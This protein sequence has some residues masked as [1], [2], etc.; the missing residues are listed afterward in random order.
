M[1]GAAPLAGAAAL[2]VALIAGPR[3]RLHHHPV[4]RCAPPDSSAS[5][6]VAAGVGHED[7]VERRA[8]HA[9]RAD[10]HP[11]LG[12]QPRHELLAGRDEE[13][14]PR[15]RTTCASIVEALG[16]R[17]DRRVVVLGLDP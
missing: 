4:A 12:E 16:E 10:R 11:E 13:R 2:S 6:I 7:V 3:H 9:D 1:T 14:R 15:P 5:R 17:G 8:R